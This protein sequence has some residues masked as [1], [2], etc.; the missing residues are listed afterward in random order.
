[1]TKLM[2]KEF[3]LLVKELNMKENGQMIARKDMGQK[4]GKMAQYIEVIIEMEKKKD[5]ENIIG[6][7]E[8]NMSVIG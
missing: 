2:E 1:M 8:V 4:H 7:M 6:Q 3:I 5:M